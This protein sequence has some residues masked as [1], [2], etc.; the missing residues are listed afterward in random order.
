MGSQRHRPDLT[1]GGWH[2]Y[3]GAMRSVLAS[4]LLAFAA[5]ARGEDAPAPRLEVPEAVY[6]A[7]K[8][9][10]GTPLRHAF[11]LKNVGTAEMS[12]D[13]KPG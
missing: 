3:N 10:R 13:A 8:V 11:V 1:A 9:Q 5:V 12:V 2:A 4:I 7:G 6:D